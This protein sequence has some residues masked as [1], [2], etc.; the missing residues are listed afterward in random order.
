MFLV[1]SFVDSQ[2][3][4]LIVYYKVQSHYLTGCY[5]QPQYLIVCYIQPQYLIV[6]YKVRPQYL[7]VC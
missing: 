7:T 3:Q 2:P 6:G 4:Y 1:V 5:I